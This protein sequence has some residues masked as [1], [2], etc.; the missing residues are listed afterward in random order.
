M[1]LPRAENNYR[2]GATS[3]KKFHA[4]RIYA[5]RMHFGMSRITLSK[6]VSIFMLNATKLRLHSI[7]DCFFFISWFILLPF[8][9]RFV[10]LKLQ[11]F[12]FESIIIGVAMQFYY[13]IYCRSSALFFHQPIQPDNKA[14]FSVYV[15]W[16]VIF[17]SI[18][19]S[20]VTLAC[21][22][23]QQSKVKQSKRNSAFTSSFY[24]F[25]SALLEQDI[26]WIAIQFIIP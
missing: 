24:T 2:N 15:N 4:T 18:T 21:S 20:R 7:F 25:N 9:S 19:L 3:N 23:H 12:S 1:R 16:K 13:N 6:D 10:G 14:N 8:L 26:N 11:T 22:I 17:N 5:I